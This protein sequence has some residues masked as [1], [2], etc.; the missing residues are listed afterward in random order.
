VIAGL[1]A[2]AI[3]ALYTGA[4]AYVNVV[5]LP[6]LLALDDKA[7]L[8]GWREALRRGFLVQ[9][10]FCV[11]GFLLGAWAWWQTRAPGNAIG[12]LAMLA[13]IPWTLAVIAPLNQTLA[14][15]TPQ[16][17]GPLAR[18]VI[19]HWGSLHTART[20]LG[21]VAVLAFLWPVAS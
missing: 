7:M 15:S 2:L 3:A 13:N 6:L 11:L 18:T 10:P 17:A 19:R 12:A 14:G 1:L 21:L 4:A 16:E 20:V 8:A 5:E 9:A